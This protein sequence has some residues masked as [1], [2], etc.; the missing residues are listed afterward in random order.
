MK[1]SKIYSNDNRFKT[2]EFNEGFNLIVG[3]I[4]CK[5]DLKKDSHNLGKTILIDLIDFLLL[6]KINQKHFLKKH[7][8]HFLNHVFFL[9]L[10]L[11][12]GNYITIKRAVKNNTKISI[13]LHDS[14]NQNFVNELE[15][16]YADLALT[17]KKPEE[18]P[19]N[20]L[21]NLLGF[22]I[23]SDFDYRKSV[24]YFFRTQNDYQDV[25]KLFK[26]K[27]KDFSWKPLLMEL[28]GFDK[29][30][31]LNKYQLIE[32]EET[33]R[34][35]I[36]NME[37]TYSVNTSKI[38][39]IKSLISIRESERD[40]LIEKSN[41][42]DFNENDLKSSNNLIDNI[43]PRIADLNSK[44]YDL[45]YEI[46]KINESLKADSNYN[47]DEI[48]EL[49][50]EVKIYF[51][52]QIKKEYSELIE[53]NNKITTERNKYLKETLKEKEEVLKEINQ[54]LD[55]L[56]VKRKDILNAIKEYDSFKK[57][58]GYQK[59]IVNL[60]IEIENLKNELNNIDKIKVENQQL[61]K[62][63]D[64][65]K[66]CNK[67]IE[68][69]VYNN[70]NNSIYENI[71]KD[72][73]ISL[74]EIIDKQGLIS[75]SINKNGNVDFNCEIL[76][77]D[78]EVTSEAKGYTYKKILCA[79]FDIAIIK[80]YINKSF[81]RCT[82][83]DGCLESL[84]PRKQQKYLDWI[85]KQCEEY[86]IQYILTAIDSDIPCKVSKQEVVLNLYD[87]NSEGTLFGFEF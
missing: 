43:E 56:N 70:E 13:K 39:K 3:R 59:E 54:E 76:N 5:N 49:Y 20:I 8:K 64:S 42:F 52:S 62:I 36:K 87:D 15:W 2:I 33:Q 1:L 57:F 51:G 63:E 46:N 6:K 68:Y 23:L 38:D 34:K 44:R 32:D 66:E 4:T 82:Y 85:R 40:N 24:N 67:K 27:G 77:L 21:N 48:L 35:F 16:D 22:D 28:L 73:Y 74:K 10:K 86:N 75:I 11:N 69:I 60:E 18:N 41:E 30:Y 29:S 31:I 65:I 45:N 12:N 84:D 71:K 81:Y 80:N 58:K 37:K 17:S 47:L 78:N 14:P 83:H 9:E 19:K 26:F 55:K 25:F 61:L 7:E 79:C 50:N 53:F 72:F